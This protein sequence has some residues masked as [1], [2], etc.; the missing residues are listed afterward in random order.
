MQ[1]TEIMPFLIV[2]SDISLLEKKFTS[3]RRRLTFFEK[4]GLFG[5]L[6]YRVLTF[7]LVKL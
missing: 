1:E 5:T 3:S 2:P 7:C 6:C 4:T